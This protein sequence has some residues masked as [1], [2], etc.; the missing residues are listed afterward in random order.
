[1]QRNR[2]PLAVRGC[3]GMGIAF[4]EKRRKTAVARTRVHGTTVSATL[5]N[6]SG[7]LL[8]E[9]QQSVSAPRRDARSATPPGLRKRRDKRGRPCAAASRV[10]PKEPPNM[11]LVV[12]RRMGAGTESFPQLQ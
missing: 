8:S 2:R 12:G 7:P 11:R 1:M 4:S 3:L 5:K 10:A 9:H 6:A